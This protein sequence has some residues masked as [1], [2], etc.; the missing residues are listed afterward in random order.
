MNLA[1]ISE[2]NLNERPLALQRKP[3]Y[4]ALTPRP[5]NWEA[6]NAA[7]LQ[8]EEE[9]NAAARTATAAAVPARSAPNYSA[10]PA[11][12]TMAPEMKLLLLVRPMIPI[13]VQMQGRPRGP[14]W[15]NCPVIMPLRQWQEGHQPLRVRL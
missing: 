4:L 5:A 6:V 10:R 1:V 13:P 12:S 11:P 2:G 7:A 3:P 8:L 14:K 15:F 9:L